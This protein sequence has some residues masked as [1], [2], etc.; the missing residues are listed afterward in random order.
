VLHIGGGGQDPAS[1]GP[2]ATAEL[3]NLNDLGAGWQSAGTMQFARRH[4]NATLLPTNQV[5]VTGGTAS[6]GPFNAAGAV[7][8]AELWSP[9]EAG[10]PSGAWATLAPMAFTRVYHSTAL[11]LPDGRVLSGGGGQ[12]ESTGDVDHKNAEI[13]SPPYVFKERP[14]ITSAPA[15]GKYGETL[16]V[17][18]PEAN[19][20][21]RV[22]LIR[23]GSVTHAFDQNQRLVTLPFSIAG[24]VLQVTLPASPNIA[25]PGH[26]MLFIV[27]G[28]VPS[29]STM[30]RLHG[31]S[32]DPLVTMATTVRAIHILQLRSR[33]NLLRV[34]FGLQP[35]SWTD[36]ALS[37]GAT[38]V[39]AV[40]FTDLRTA[41]EGA[42]VAAGQALPTFSDP[43]IAKIT[44]IGAFHLSELR[45]R[46]AA[47]E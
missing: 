33:I 41:L 17:Q 6:P 24:G 26:Y 2:S 45:D 37:A 9:P 34:R 23:L 27:N 31:F 29:V 16:A 10:A 20:I 7:L 15:S 30:L 4:L 40:H 47:L 36:A 19:S 1:S 12:P 11:L 38:Q 14:T 22:S 8:A 25:P 21:T 18:T 5:L 44:T 28:D 3:L 32:D 39:R 42:Y 35:F 13:F 46:V 43:L